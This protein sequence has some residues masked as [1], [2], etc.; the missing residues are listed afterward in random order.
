[1]DDTTIRVLLYSHDSQ[2]LGHVRR[3]LALAHHLARTIPERTGRPVS[4]LLVSGLPMGDDV[5]LP[6]GFDWLTIPGVAKGSN[7]YEPRNLAGPTSRLIDLRS[8][9]IESAMLSFA[10]DLVV[11]DRHIYGVWRELR[12]PLRRLRARRPCARVVLGLR[13]VLDEPAAA[14]AEWRALGDLSELRRLV[15]EVWVYG[16]QDVHDPIAS[17]EVPLALADKVRFTG[18]LANGR[19]EL[20]GAG[21]PRRAPFILTT[22]G[23]G[24][25]GHD[26]L[27]AAAAMDV[28]DG[29]EHVIVTGPQLADATAV[30]ALAGPR[31]HVHRSWPGLS[32]QIADADA[33]I[34]M[35][36]YNTT[37][38]ILATDT[39]ALIVPRE[40]PRREQLIRARSLADVGALD[41]M[42]AEQMSPAAL[43]SWAAGAVG[44]HVSRS[45]LALD[46]LTT[47]A[48]YAAELLADAAALEASP[49]RPRI[50][51]VLKVYPRFSETFVV[52][53]MLAREA[54]GDDL[55]IYALRPTTDQRFHPEIARVGARVTWVPR[56]L[57]ATD[58]WEQLAGAVSHPRLRENLAGLL[59]ELAEL[60]GDE[61]AQGVALAR[62]VL[63]DGITH[64]H[65]H[66]ASLAGRMTWLASR[67]TGVPYTVTTHAKDIFHDSVDLFWLRRIC[68]DAERV[69]AISEFNE[70]YLRQVLDGTGARVSLQYNALELAR[71][72][73]HDPPRVSA[74]LRVAA[75]GRLVPKK[76]F[77]DLIDAVAQARSAGL[78]VT[79]SIAGDGEL[80]G[81]LAARIRRRGLTGHV[82]LL[83]PL[84]QEEVKRLLSGAHVFAAPCI[85]AADGNIDG[86]P[87][88]VLEA[89]ASGTPVI[90]T[91]VSGL[92]EVVRD[93]D[94]GILLDPG[95]VDALAAA[96][97]RVAAGG[98]DLTGMARNA[99]ALIEE[100]FD[101]RKQAAALS[102][103]E[104]GEAGGGER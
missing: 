80:A 47:A 84:T 17:G 61:V 2:G 34:A 69:V 3:N 10:P 27:R 56:P 51:Y 96:L 83:G 21:E 74:P 87:T 93:Q 13:E 32:N 53:E 8:V 75:L 78:D 85:Q 24:S 97:T 62:S 42:R 25:D 33:V 55:S 54:L 15:D 43:G 67:L 39:P 71:F 19:R 70:A 60:P 98:Y 90:A 72:P 28:P 7:G 81:E 23:G 40:E 29:Y 100:K 4:G 94:T 35:G 65:A 48:R 46:G 11:I 1:M 77:A 14:A 38:E 103:W 76:G 31:T 18:Y 50:G 5:L 9:L 102:T 73:Y 99:R 58:M 41:V 68:G 88:V 104:A 16:D 57:K 63:E 6:Q 95:D 49:A 22:A 64:L 82:R 86:L 36:G 59:P 79:A 44:R 92:P 12:R 20:D 91:S 52:T 45:A 66:F 89:M 101:S 30:Q 26:L 37:C